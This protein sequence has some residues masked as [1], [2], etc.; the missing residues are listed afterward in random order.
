MGRRG[1]LQAAENREKQLSNAREILYAAAPIVAE[2][3]ATVAVGSDTVSSTDLQ[4]MSSVL[5]RTLGK[6]AHVELSMTSA[7]QTLDILRELDA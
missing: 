4:A 1:G 7:Q 2:R 6:T 3:L 5:D